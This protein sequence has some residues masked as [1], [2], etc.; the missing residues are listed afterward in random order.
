M[1]SLYEAFAI[2]DGD[3]RRQKLIQASQTPLSDAPVVPDQ[4]AFAAHT[5][6]HTSNRKP[7]VCKHCNVVGH[8]KDRCFQLHPELKKQYAWPRNP[9]PTRFV[10]IAETS[11]DPTVPDIDQLHQNQSL[12]QTQLGQ[13]QSQLGSLLQ[14]HQ[15]GSST[16]AIA[17]GTSTALHVKTGSPRWVLDSGANDHMTGELSLFS[18]PLTP[19]NQTV[20]IADGSSTCVHSKGDVCLSPH[21]TLSFVL[22]VPQLSFNLLSV[23]RLAK[24]Y[25]CAVIFSPHHCLLQD[26]NSKKKIGRA[27][28]RERVCQY[29]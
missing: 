17:T 22:H 19:V 9:G 1:P 29:V 24:S 21:L 6:P 12:L 23:S 14:Q 15:S 28:C 27:S 5:G 20:S 2:V 18:S 7:P 3:E 16:A 13:I 8:T 11:P 26:L 10:A 4:M 25:N